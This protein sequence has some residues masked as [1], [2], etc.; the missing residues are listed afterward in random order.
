LIVLNQSSQTIALS[1]GTHPPPVLT[2]DLSANGLMMGIWFKSSW[3]DR[4][5]QNLDLRN[6]TPA[7]HG[8]HRKIRL[9]RIDLRHHPELS[10]LSSEGDGR[11]WRMVNHQARNCFRLGS[12]EK[13]GN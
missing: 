10:Q 7:P 12:N 1:H 2:I 9:G 11:N 5:I 3:R 6:K 8:F 13:Q 4:R